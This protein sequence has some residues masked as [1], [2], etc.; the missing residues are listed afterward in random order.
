MFITYT[1]Y[2]YKNQIML[3]LSV[4]CDWKS[5]KP[6]DHFTKSKEKL[7]IF[8]QI[9][10]YRPNFCVPSLF[11]PIKVTNVF[12][13]QCF[14]QGHGK[15]CHYMSSVI[16]GMVQGNIAFKHFYFL[17]LV[18]KF[19]LELFAWNSQGSFTSYHWWSIMTKP[20][21]F[22][23]RFSKKSCHKKC[24]TIQLGI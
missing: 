18:D 24:K 14:V 2:F 12:E 5:V 22:P 7:L 9:A 15:N 3:S 23:D 11:R 1:F 8:V 16:S 20:N 13:E 19:Y 21:S 17:T 6:V 10:T 4:G